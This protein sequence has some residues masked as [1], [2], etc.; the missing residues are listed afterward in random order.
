ARIQAYRDAMAERG[1]DVQPRW[2]FSRCYDV[3]DGARVIHEILHMNERPSAML[4]TSD[5]VAAGMLAE[6]ARQGIR[7][8]EDLAMIGFDNHPLA[9]VL[10]IT[11]IDNQL[12]EMGMGAFE[13]VHTAIERGNR[14]VETRELKYRLIER[15]T[16]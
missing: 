4:V 16:V 14:S 13:M 8:P 3:E 2:M 12:F 10:R 15:G 7:V 5:H 9:R 1:M 11:T 6:G